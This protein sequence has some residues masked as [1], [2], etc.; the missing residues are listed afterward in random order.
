[1]PDATVLPTPTEI[2][3]VDTPVVACDGGEGALGHPRV[4]L[5]IVSHD[6][7]CPYCSRLFVL[8]D[9]VAPDTGH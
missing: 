8:K 6:V 2:I 1:M 4:W 5:R 3:P 7:M 9:G